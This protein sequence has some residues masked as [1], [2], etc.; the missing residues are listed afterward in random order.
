[1]QEFNNTNI[2]NSRRSLTFGLAL[3]TIGS[4]VAGDAFL[5]TLAQSPDNSTNIERS[6]VNTSNIEKVT[7]AIHEPVKVSIVLGS[8]VLTV[9]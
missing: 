6:N 9:M 8:S 1:M 7:A 4:I 3:L 5:E 2:F